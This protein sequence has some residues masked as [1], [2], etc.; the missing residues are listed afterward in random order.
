MIR[1]IFLA[2]ALLLSGCTSPAY[3][4]SQADRRYTAVKI[5]DWE[6]GNGSPRTIRVLLVHGMGN[7]PFG[8]DGKTGPQLFQQNTY[9]DLQKWLKENQHDKE[10]MKAVRAAA[11]E[12]SWPEFIRNSSKELGH[13]KDT[14]ADPGFELVSDSHSNPIGYVF[15]QSYKANGNG[16]QL[17]FYIA[18]W[19]LGTA[20]RKERRFGSWNS[21]TGGANRIDGDVSDF[22]PELNAQRVWGNKKLKLETMDWGLGDAALYM[23]KTPSLAKP[24]TV[25]LQQLLKDSGPNDRIAV[26]THSLGSTITLDA[27]VPFLEQPEARPSKVVPG[28]VVEGKLASLA[29]PTEGPRDVK[30]SGLAFYMFANQYGLL[31]MGMPQ[32]L[33]KL[34]KALATS[35][36]AKE[37]AAVQLYAYTDPNDLLSYPINLNDSHKTSISVCNVYVKNRTLSLGIFVDPLGAHVNYESNPHVLQTMLNSPDKVRL[38]DSP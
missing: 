20:V 8:S 27:L 32:S 26:V 11:E 13:A 18:N 10:K 14:H 37:K 29:Q 9:R 25:A 34:N 31:T 33:E 2:L 35:D 17:K 5:K 22:D 24:V 15:T 12:S 4:W 16:V 30:P 36:V 19:G 3:L 23:S 7:H 6:T 38:P 1:P 21:L 28:R